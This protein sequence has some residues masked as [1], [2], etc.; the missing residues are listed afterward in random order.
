MNEE[1][2]MGMR[3]MKRRYYK[4]GR[5]ENRGSTTKERSEMKNKLYKEGGM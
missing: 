2:G 3:D 1:R 5:E 4:N